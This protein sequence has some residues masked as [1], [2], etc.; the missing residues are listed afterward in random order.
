MHVHVPAGSAWCY[1]AEEVLAVPVDSQ[2]QAT[3]N[4]ND[5]VLAEYLHHLT[6]PSSL[7]PSFFI[8]SIHTIVPENAAHE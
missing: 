8:D 2:T 5:S 4:C 1:S 7:S 3:K 6:K